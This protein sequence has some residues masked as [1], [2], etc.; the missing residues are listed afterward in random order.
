[1]K[2]EWLSMAWKVM[3]ARGVVGVVFGAI[4]LAWPGETAAAFVVLWGIWALVDGIGSLVEGFSPGGPRWPTVLMGLVS[5]VVAF[6]A[7]F[8]P[9]MTASAVT[10]LLGIWLILRGVFELGSAALGSAAGG[11]AFLVAVGVVDLGLGVLF[12]ANP[13]RAAVAIAWLLGLV[14]LLWGLVFL[15]IGLVVRHQQ[16]EVAHEDPG[17]SSLSPSS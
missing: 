11:R 17:S 13:G 2:D 10:L 5:L 4:A 9:A 7:I 1:M 12:V 8:S 16:R 6:F 15:A 3:V 14:A